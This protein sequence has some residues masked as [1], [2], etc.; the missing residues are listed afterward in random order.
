MNNINA[1]F[2]YMMINVRDK[3][4]LKTLGLRLRTMR[5]S[6]DLSQEKLANEADISISQVSRIERGLLN[7][8]L[9]TLASLANALDV[10]LKDLVD[11]GK[12]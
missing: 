6:A 8:T 12:E 4:L 2:L 7:P 10:E 9:C 1:R 11:I 5:K 3:E